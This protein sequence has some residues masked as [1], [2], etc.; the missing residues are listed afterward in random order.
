ML[1]QDIWV[2]LD[3]D[4]SQNIYLKSITQMDGTGTVL[5]C[6][7]SIALILGLGQCCILHVT[8]HSPCTDMTG[9]RD[10]NDQVE[11]CGKVKDSKLPLPGM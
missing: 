2:F 9:L 1:L 10:V 6:F 7:K 4:H 11:I 8:S 3:S 5:W